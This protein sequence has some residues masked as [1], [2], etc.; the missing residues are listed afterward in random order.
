M[1]TYYAFEKV[2]DGFRSFSSV[3]IDNGMTHSRSLSIIHSTPS[4][5]EKETGD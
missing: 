4:I 2:D 5:K 1:K 3:Q